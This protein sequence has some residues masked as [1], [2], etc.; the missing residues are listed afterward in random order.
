MEH[1]IIELFKPEDFI[2]YD[3]IKIMP[4]KENIFIDISLL[5]TYDEIDLDKI[6]LKD[7]PDGT[8]TNYW[9]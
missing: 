2:D 7:I 5:I 3:K 8:K 1:D 4:Q 6:T 9:S